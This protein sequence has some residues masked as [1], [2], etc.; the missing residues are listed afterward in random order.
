MKCFSIFV[1]FISFFSSADNVIDI[2]E[3]LVRDL[4]DSL[5]F[6]EKEIYYCPDNTCEI[7]RA[8]DIK[9]LP[10]YVYLYLYHKSGTIYLKE[11]FDK[12]E[13]FIITAVE[14]PNIIEGLRKYCKETDKTPTC[15]IEGLGRAINIEVGSARYDEGYFC[16]GYS[17][18]ENICKKL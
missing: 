18:N 3:L 7:F 1:L 8:K 15:V 17:K 2:K 10:S 16:Y 14:E 4:K 5:E 11:S 9:L 13:T 12:E 6:R